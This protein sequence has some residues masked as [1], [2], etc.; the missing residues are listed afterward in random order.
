MGD[1]ASETPERPKLFDQLRAA[2][3]VH[4]YSI[5][6]LDEILNCMFR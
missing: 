4:N 3:R 5:R 6:T 1:Y 2:I